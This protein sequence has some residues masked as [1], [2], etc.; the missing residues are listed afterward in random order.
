MPA[1]LR[2]RSLDGATSNRGK[3][4]PIAAYYSSI[5][6]EGMKGLLRVRASLDS[7]PSSIT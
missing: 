4:H 1:F 3:R 5:G 7:V 2:K 6:P